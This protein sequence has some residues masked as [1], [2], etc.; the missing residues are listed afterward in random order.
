MMTAQLLAR[1]AIAASQA[2]SAMRVGQNRESESNARASTAIISR[3]ISSTIASPSADYAQWMEDIGR[4][5]L[6]YL[7][8]V[9]CGCDADRSFKS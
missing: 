7:T 9:R 6:V 3:V 5:G 8:L 2:R 1:S 4:T